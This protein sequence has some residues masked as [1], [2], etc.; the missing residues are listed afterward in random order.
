MICLNCSRETPTEKIGLR[1]GAGIV[2]QRCVDKR[3]S[4]APQI[5]ALEE[6]CRAYGK[7]EERPLM[8]D[9]SW[10]T[11]DGLPQLSREVLKELRRLVRV[12][13]TLFAGWII[14]QLLRHFGII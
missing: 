9:I 6:L 8:D 1:I 7:W 13:G 3:S 11:A 5:R 4:Y 10:R 12:C 2:C 14:L